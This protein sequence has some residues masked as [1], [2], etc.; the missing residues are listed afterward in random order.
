MRFVSAFIVAFLLLS[1]LEL[2]A[3]NLGDALMQAWQAEQSNNPSAAASAYA[4][5]LSLRP[6]NPLL[7]LKYAEMLILLDRPNEVARHLVQ[8]LTL[9]SKDA[10]APVDLKRY[11]CDLLM[12]RLPQ[13]IRWRRM[14]LGYDYEGWLYPPPFATLPVDEQKRIPQ[15][16]PKEW[17][18]PTKAGE[19]WFLLSIGEQEKGLKLLQQAAMEG[20]PKGAIHALM[21]RFVTNEQRI[22]IAQSWR[23]DAEGSSN[24]FLW[25]TALHLLWR[26]QQIEAFRADFPKALGAMKDQPALL[27]ELANLCEKMRWDKELK[28]VRELLPFTLKPK[29]E[30]EI[31]KGLSQALEEGDLAK[32]KALV[33]V[34]AADFPDRFRI[35]VLDANAIRKMLGH[36][37]HEF[38]VE[39][40]QLDLVPDLP[41]DTKQLLLRDAAF[42][43][44]RF[45][46]WLRLFMSQPVGDVRESTVNLLEMTGGDIAEREPERSIWLLEQGLLIFPNEPRLVK[47]LALMYE[48]VGYPH[49]AIAMLK[50]TLSNEFKADFKDYNTLSRLWDIC[51]RHQQSDEL[52]KWLEGQKAQMPLSAYSAVARLWWQHNKPAEALRWLDEA[53]AIAKERNWLSD[54]EIHAQAYYL[55]RT[56]DPQA[57]PEAMKLQAKT[58]RTGM[59]FHP[60]TYELRLDCLLRLG[61]VE[62]AKQ[63]F[64]E[65]KRLY[66]DYPFAERVHGLTSIVV[67]DWAEELKRLKGE[68]RNLDAPNY[69]TLVKIAYATVKAGQA[70]KREQIA[71]ELMAGR[72]QLDGGLLVCH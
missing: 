46:H 3:Q 21:S 63:V 55:L 53:L 71:D 33:R 72:P 40:V 65:G 22:Q 54:A 23:R 64:E 10:T 43:P 58:A 2:L 56:P 25:L 52:I 28:Q 38:V 44:S 35:L 19:A 62:E 5:A 11:V 4:Q 16:V 48:R 57:V 47:N 36:G 7:H 39:L 69:D 29:E 31:R 68:W 26:T 70:D 17:L 8:A 27:L 45:S 6:N 60:D 67:T 51:H 20:D 37:W 14:S 32:V 61:K 34:I 1:G 18:F 24:P 50:E 13:E 12:G 15:L 66:P 30:T 9:F 41:Y 42:S 49:R 59:L